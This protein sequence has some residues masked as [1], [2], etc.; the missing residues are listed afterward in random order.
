[1]CTRHQ[2]IKKINEFIRKEENRGYYDKFFIKFKNCKPLQLHQRNLSVIT[3]ISEINFKKLKKV[4][5][6]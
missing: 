4:E 1:M 5:K 6:K 3:Y 2:S